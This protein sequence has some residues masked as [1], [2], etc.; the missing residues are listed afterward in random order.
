MKTAGLFA[1]QWRSSVYALLESLL[2]GWYAPPWQGCK[3]VGPVELSASSHRITA[4][5]EGHVGGWVAWKSEYGGHKDEGMSKCRD[6]L[7][8]YAAAMSLTPFRGRGLPVIYQ[9]YKSV[10]LQRQ[11]N[12]RP[13]ELDETGHA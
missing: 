11:P 13:L 12:S 3:F 8:F 5:A 2:H 9:L 10:G 6:V 1:Y 4:R 7:W